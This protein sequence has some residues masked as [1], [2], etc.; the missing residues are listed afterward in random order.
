MDEGNRFQQDVEVASWA[1]AQRGRGQDVQ[2]EASMLYRKF[3][4]TKQEPLRLAVALRG[5]FMEEGVSDDQREDYGKYLK[6]RIRPAMEELIG[7][8]AVEKMQVFEDLGWFDDRHLEGFIRS[9][10]N[11]KK[12]ASLVWLLHLKDEKYGYQDYDFTL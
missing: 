10:R 12:T 8:E 5:Y 7:E 6:G 11:R 2:K 3:K 9:A 4:E 1:L